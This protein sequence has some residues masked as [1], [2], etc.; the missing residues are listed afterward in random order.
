MSKV[1]VQ[2][3]KRKNMRAFRANPFTFGK[4]FFTIT[5][6]APYVWGNFHACAITIFQKPQQLGRARIACSSIAT[7]ESE[8]SPRPDLSGQ[9]CCKLRLRL[10]LHVCSGS[11]GKE[12][13]K[14]DRRVRHYKEVG[15]QEWPLAGRATVPRVLQCIQKFFPKFCLILIKK[16]DFWSDWAQL[17][18]KTLYAIL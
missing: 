14:A 16:I 7:S 10:L 13:L 6:N 3:D 5:K 17:S 11:T 8:P 12:D 15:L 2:A 18:G 4:K 9:R 1:V